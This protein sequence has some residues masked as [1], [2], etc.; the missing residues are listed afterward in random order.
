MTT[1]RPPVTTTPPPVTTTPPPVTTTPPPPPPLT[2]TVADRNDA[3][4]SGIPGSQVI[5]SVLVT[6]NGTQRIDA[7]TVV[8]TAPPGA[9]LLNGYLG[10]VHETG[11][12]GD[13]APG[14]LAPDGSTSTCPA[15][16]VNLDPGQWIVFY[17]AVVIDPGA[18][19]GPASVTFTLGAPAFASGTGSIAV[20]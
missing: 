18:T 15:V 12:D 2:A 16:P 4:G 11:A 14:T 10:W 13:T 20:L 9:R 17:T 3:N 1:T 6:N 7:Q 5:A 19:P 8:L